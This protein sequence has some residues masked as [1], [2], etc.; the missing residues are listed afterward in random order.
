MLHA[1]RLHHL[2]EG[3]HQTIAVRQGHKETS[4]SYS[5]VGVVEHQGSSLQS[6][7]YVA[8]VQRGAS[9]SADGQAARA[10]TASPEV[11]P[12]SSRPST[13]AAASQSD[14][15][16]SAQHQASAAAAASAT[17]VVQSPSLAA[18]QSP[19]ASHEAADN[20][21]RGRRPASSSQEEVATSDEAADG[22]TGAREPASSSQEGGPA[23]HEAP[24][25]QAGSSSTEPPSAPVVGEAPSLQS[26]DVADRALRSCEPD[27]YCISDTHVKRV[28]PEAVAGCEAYLL[29]YMRA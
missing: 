21:C 16:P 13:D 27:W 20:R 15:P 3:N 9:T 29:L 5:L 24:A 10:D 23:S 18:P 22:G 12:I 19:E 11:E 26:A 17:D 25:E 2:A 8:Y 7:H 6:G 14:L 28:S 1:P 4:M